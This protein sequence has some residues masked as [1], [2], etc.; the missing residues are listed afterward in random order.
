[1]PHLMHLTFRHE[2]LHNVETHL[3]RRILEQPQVIEPGSGQ[4]TPFIAMGGRVMRDWVM[5]PQP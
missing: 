1:M 5:I 2:N 4:A 3:H